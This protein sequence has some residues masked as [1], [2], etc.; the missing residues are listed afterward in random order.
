[1]KSCK[2]SLRNLQSCIHRYTLHIKQRNTAHQAQAAE[3]AAVAEA[4]PVAVAAVLLGGRPMVSE[5]KLLMPSLAALITAAVGLAFQLW[6]ADTTPTLYYLL[7]IAVAAL[8]AFLFQTAMQRRDPVVDWLVCGVGVLAL[9]QIAPIPYLGLGYIAAGILS[10]AGAFPAAALAGLALDL[11]RITPVP[12]TAVLSLSYLLRLLPWH[13]AKLYYLA[14]GAVYLLVMSVNGVW[15]IHPV[16]PLVLGWYILT[17]L[18]SILENA[19]KLGAH[20]PGW[21]VKL[22]QAGKDAM[23]Q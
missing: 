14:P 2:V 9:A 17:E 20:V 16:L 3:A 6:Q 19:V 1:M 4:A 8:S 23:E 21:L 10:C 22:L 12:M 7:R 13:R 18:G 5:V 11:A 15:D